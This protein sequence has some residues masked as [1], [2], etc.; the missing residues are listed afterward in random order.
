MQALL[1]FCRRNP[2]G[3]LWLY[4]K[5]VGGSERAREVF[6]LAMQSGPALVFGVLAEE[7]G[8]D[9]VR[10]T[11]KRFGFPWEL[12]AAAVLQSLDVGCQ[13]GETWPIFRTLHPDRAYQAMRMVVFRQEEGEGYWIVFE[14]LEGSDEASLCLKRYVH[15]LTEHRLLN[16][17]SEAELFLEGEWEDSGENTLVGPWGEESVNE[18]RLL[19][20]EPARATARDVENMRFTLLVRAYLEACPGA[21]WS[22]EAMLRRDLDLEGIDVEDYEV[23]LDSDAFQHVVGTAGAEMDP[24]GIDAAWRKLPSES[25][26]YQSLARAM[27]AGDPSLFEPGV[28]NLDWRLHLDAP[29]A[30]RRMT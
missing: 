4:E 9:S 7:L 21:F 30:K 2:S 23:F 5:L 29:N 8:R 1:E 12:T 6:A 22:D 24:E 20:L 18:Q 3:Y 11:F 26:V 10:A 16:R 17:S 27:V 13:E 25:P 28:S 15:G 14:T 19:G